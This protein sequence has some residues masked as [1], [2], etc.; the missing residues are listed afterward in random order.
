MASGRVAASR[1]PRAAFVAAVEAASRAASAADHAG[2]AGAW[3]RAARIAEDAGSM[4]S[5]GPCLEA[6]GE[7]WRRADAPLR[8][9][10]CLDGA[11]QRGHGGVGARVRTASLLAERGRGAEAIAALRAVLAVARGPERALA[12]DT[13]IGALQ[14][15]GQLGELT[16]ELDQLEAALNASK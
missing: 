2:A 16:A 13:L 5:V 6:A 14:G 9:L 15:Y 7:A 11:V 4:G 3:E 8:A 10:D 1:D 12:L